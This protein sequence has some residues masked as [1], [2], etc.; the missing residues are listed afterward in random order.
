MGR[1]HQPPFLG[2]RGGSTAQEEAGL[3]LGGADRRTVLLRRVHPSSGTFWYFCLRP[4]AQQCYTFAVQVFIL[5]RFFSDAGSSLVQ[6]FLLFRCFCDAGFSVMQVFLLC[7]ALYRAEWSCWE[8]V[9]QGW[10][11]IKK[12]WKP[13]LSLLSL[14][15]KSQLS[16]QEIKWSLK[17][18]LDIPLAL[19][20]GRTQT[21]PAPILFCCTGLCY[22]K[23]NSLY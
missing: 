7:S 3:G 12:G 21:F 9:V 23:Q 6:M 4:S 13:V 2:G 11:G 19:P 1:K 10:E 20:L 8:V 17:A 14:F 16:Y 5:C 15:S 18:S 22:K